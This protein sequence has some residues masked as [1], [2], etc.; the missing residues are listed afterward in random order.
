VDHS[1]NVIV[2]GSFRGTLDLGGGAL[3]ADGQ[4]DGFA[5]GLAPDLS[6][7]WSERYG[8]GRDDEVS[9]VVV[10]PGGEIY[11]AGSFRETVDFDGTLLTSSGSSDIFVH[12]I[13]P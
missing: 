12:R 2:V 1:G 7:R 9:A 3:I 5:V 4:E 11:L 6:H 8:S 10:G 13:T